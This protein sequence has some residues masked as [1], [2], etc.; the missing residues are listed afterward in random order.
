MW[1]LPAR[2]AAFT[3]I[4][5]SA[6]RSSTT[7][8]SGRVAS[9]LA[10][11]RNAPSTAVTAMAR[12]ILSRIASSGTTRMSVGEKPFQAPLRLRQR[13]LQVPQLLA[14][15]ESHVPRHAEVLAWH[16]QHTVLGAQLLDQVERTRRVLVPRPADRSRLRCLPAEPVP[17]TIEPRLEDREI[18]RENPPRPLEQLLA[19]QGIEGDGREVVARARRANGGGVVARPR[20]G[21]E[22]GRRDDPADAQAGQPVRLGEPV[23]HDDALVTSPKG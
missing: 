18:R 21:A 14:V 4:S 17:E 1:R 22:L 8:G 19:H 9:S 3:W 2:Y 10:R 15:A 12:G 13:V 7:I 23:H 20:V 6:S 11:A 16:E 5:A